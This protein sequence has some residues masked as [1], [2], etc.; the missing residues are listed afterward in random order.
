MSKKYPKSVGACVDLLYQR[1]AE[2]LAVQARVEELKADE[3]DL[4]RHIF[5][6][7]GKQELRGAK[8]TVASAS[9]KEE[10]VPTMEDW[11][12]FRAW[13]VKTK[14]W[15]LLQKRLSSTAVRE[16]WNAGKEVPGVGVFHKMSLSLTKV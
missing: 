9:I 12:A 11:E 14:S 2:R 16:R 1:R 3:A 8:G 7:F 6:T 4:E 13:V 10:N 15:D 5:N